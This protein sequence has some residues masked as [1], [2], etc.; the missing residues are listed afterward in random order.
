V[1]LR[2]LGEKIVAETAQWQSHL[3]TQTAARVG[4]TLECAP[5]VA[6][7]ASVDERL[8]RHVLQNLVQNG[9]KY[10]NPQA[11]GGA[12]VALRMRLSATQLEV[13]VEDNGIG[14][15][16]K[17]LPAMFTDFHRASN[18]GHTPGTGLGLSI[19]RRAVEAHGG[20]IRAENR[21]GGGAVFSGVIPLGGAL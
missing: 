7:V 9:C 5:G 20:S 2:R 17:D 11:V 10:A 15:P 6:D 21:A 12:W 8:L 16:E 13:V 14:I 18:V 4:F 1:D 3:G 19:A